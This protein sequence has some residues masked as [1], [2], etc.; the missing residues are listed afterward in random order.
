MRGVRQ[1]ANVSR[2]ARNAARSVACSGMHD[3][4]C[5]GVGEDHDWSLSFEVQN[6]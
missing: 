3:G 4:G 6:L 2:A 5:L 1:A